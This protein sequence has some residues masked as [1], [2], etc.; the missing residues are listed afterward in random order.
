MNTKDLTT[1]TP[2]KKVA[3]A[4]PYQ[5]L[6]EDNADLYRSTLTDNKMGYQRW[7]MCAWLE[8][9]KVCDAAKL[10]S[11]SKQ[12]AIELRDALCKCAQQGFY[13]GEDCNLVFIGSSFK[14]Y[15]GYRAVLK[16][17]GRADVK[18]LK[19]G[20]VRK[21]DEYTPPTLEF[22]V[23]GDGKSVALINYTGFSHKKID[24][25][26]PVVMMYVILSVKG[27]LH[28]E[29]FGKSVLDKAVAKFA[30]QNTRGAWHTHPIEMKQKHVLRK[31]LR[32]I[33]L[34]ETD[35]QMLK[36]QDEVDHDLYLA[37][38]Q[39]RDDNALETPASEVV[40]D[41]RPP[42]AETPKPKPKPKP[43]AKAKA[44]TRARAR[45]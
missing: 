11:I 20:T 42:K 19:I 34:K 9:E 26:S 2:D 7:G 21:N 15:I 10:R 41:Q 37:R 16:A 29:Q 4:N 35:I 38:E 32:F 23:G 17:L 14:L 8:I 13:L 45:T 40:D 30:G 39:N 6:V 36:Y 3:K 5:K 31:A 27:E 18:L 28:F 24:N 33:D 1:K 43:K 22:N 12:Q 44:R 25:D